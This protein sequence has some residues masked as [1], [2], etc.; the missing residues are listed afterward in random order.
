[1][2]EHRT[3]GRPRG[4][5]IE[6]TLD[7]IKALF[8]ERGFEA[9]SLAD[10][11]AATGLRKGSLYA[12]Y[13]DKQAMYLKALARYEAGEVAATIAALQGPGEPRARLQAFLD[14]PI[15]AAYDAGD[16]R[17]C[18]LC[19]AAADRALVDPDAAA[20]VRA[21][22]ERMEQAVAAV[23]AELDPALSPETAAAVAAACVTAYAGLRVL[24]RAEMARASL[25]AA[26]D[27]VLAALPG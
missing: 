4:F 13:G 10:I 20:I 21:G 12:A 8:W 19:N 2:R 17:G 1:M 9:V 15:R 23:A 11:A 7:V 16:G 26:R 18:F 14:G 6:A 5:D 22:F 3:P 24:A 25:E 27:R